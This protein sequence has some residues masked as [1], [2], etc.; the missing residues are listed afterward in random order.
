MRTT[1]WPSLSTNQTAK[2]FTHSLGLY[3]LPC[4]SRISPPHDG[5][6]YWRFTPALCSRLFGEIFGAA[7]IRVQAYSNVFICAAALQGM[8]YQELRPH[9]LDTYDARFPLIVTVSAVKNS[10]GE[11]RSR[12]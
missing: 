9:E 1:R 5:T 12:P 10:H 7:N 4:T 11:D 2:P 8:A 6:S 3:L